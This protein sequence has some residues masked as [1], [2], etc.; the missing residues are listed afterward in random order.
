MSKRHHAID[1]IIGD[2]DARPMTRNRLRSESCLLSMKKPKIVKDA[3]EDDHWYKAMEEEIQQ[4]E[5][6]KTWSL[7]QRLEDKNMIGAKWVFIN[8]LDESGEVT[9][10]KARLVWKGYA[11]EEGI[12]YGETFNLV[13]RMERVR[14]FL[15]YATYKAFKVYQMDVKSTF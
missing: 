10:K 11:Q 14:I 8:K 3:L 7:V 4:I 1:Q 6:N 15:A 12:D 2:K 5:K 9:R 13:A